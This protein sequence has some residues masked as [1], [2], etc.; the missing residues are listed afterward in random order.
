MA[1]AA[2]AGHAAALSPPKPPAVTLQ[3]SITLPSPASRRE[4]SLMVFT[5]NVTYTAGAGPPSAA[6]VELQDELPDALV[7]E[8]VVVLNNPAA[9]E[10]VKD[11]GWLVLAALLS[12]VACKYAAP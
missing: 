8:A 5:I 1:H 12:S 11:T 10:G 7:P 4:K 6:Q 2:A 3:A 9:G